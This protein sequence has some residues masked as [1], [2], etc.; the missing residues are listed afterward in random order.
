M[1]IGNEEY[2]E[3]LVTDGNG[4]LI[5]SITDKDIIEE[6]GCKVVFKPVVL[7][8]KED[9]KVSG[10][11]EQEESRIKLRLDECIISV[12]DKIIYDKSTLSECDYIREIQALSSLVDSR[13]M[14]DR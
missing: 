4:D 6:E 10:S 14:L 11:I 13:A 7:R 3:I 8:Q 9:E 2:A 5:A 1:R 12:A